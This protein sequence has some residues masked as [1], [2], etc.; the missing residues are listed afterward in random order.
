MQFKDN[1]LSIMRRAL[2]YYLNHV[3]SHEDL[4]DEVSDTLQKVKNY[5]DNYEAK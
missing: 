1:E 4:V 5:Q 2:T 3:V